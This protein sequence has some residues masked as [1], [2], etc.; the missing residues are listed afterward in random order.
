V[1]DRQSGD[2]HGPTLDVEDPAGVIAAD[3]QQAEKARQAEQRAKAAEE[4]LQQARQGAEE[5]APRLPQ[6]GPGENKP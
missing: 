6:P 4:A 3:G 1:G 2:T 5:K